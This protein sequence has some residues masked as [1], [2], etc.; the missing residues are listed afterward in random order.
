MQFCAPFGLWVTWQGRARPLLVGCNSA[1]FLEAWE[2]F[3]LTRTRI[4]A[5]AVWFVDWSEQRL[6]RRLTGAVYLR[7]TRVALDWPQ[8]IATIN[9]GT[10]VVQK[11]PSRQPHDVLVLPSQAFALGSRLPL[12]SRRVAV[13]W[14]AGASD[15]PEVAFSLS[16]ARIL[17]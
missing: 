1:F 16:A 2:A 10:S 5:A 13:A 11:A 15:H 4:R 3:R 14:V 17:V 9:L 7:A 6:A 8:R 12:V